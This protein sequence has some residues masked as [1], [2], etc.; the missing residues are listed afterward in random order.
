[1]HLARRLSV[2]LAALC[3]V[4]AAC[5]TSGEPTTE[6]TTSVAAPQVSLSVPDSLP[7]VD[8]GAETITL[9]DG[10]QRR[11]LVTEPPAGDEA[12][13]LVM[14]LHGIGGSAAGVRDYVDVEA[15]AAE[16]DIRAVAVYPEGSGDDVGFPQS[17]NAGGCCP[18]A[19]LDEVDDVGFLGA[20]IE[21]VREKYATDPARTWVIGHSNGGMMAYRLA[22]DMPGLVSAIGVGAGALMTPCTSTATDS[23]AVSLVHL[24]GKQDMVVPFD[25]GSIAGITFPSA[26]GTLDAWGAAHDCV[27][28]TDTVTWTCRNGTTAR[29]VSDASWGHEWQPSWT[30]TMLETF[31]LAVS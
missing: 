5:G 4:T 9:A 18:F 16:L 28:A 10:T 2:A 27:A 1:M 29:L 23:A 6:T 30:R 22:C 17:W 8:D 13:A 24:H 21:R 20:V 25:G 11:Y 14:V 15:V 26:T 19:N 3:V 12:P 31:L 7:P